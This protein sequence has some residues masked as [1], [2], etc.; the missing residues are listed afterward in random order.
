MRYLHQQACQKEIKEGKKPLELW[1]R[2]PENFSTPEVEDPFKYP[3][4]NWPRDDLEQ[5]PEE[6]IKAAREAKSSSKA[7]NLIIAYLDAIDML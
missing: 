2:Y 1:E 4:Y 7:V 6:I 3:R 5:M